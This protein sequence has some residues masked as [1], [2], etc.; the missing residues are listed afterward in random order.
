MARSTKAKRI[1]YDHLT[2]L[3]IE[4]CQDGATCIEIAEVA[5]VSQYM[6]YLTL[7]DL[8]K[9]GKLKQQHQTKKANLPLIYY[10]VSTIIYH[11]HDPFGI[12]Q[13]RKVS[14]PGNQAVA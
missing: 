2:N 8:V 14:E 7:K 10:T 11:A 4:M 13:V 3:I 12:A 6:V 9:D 5:D 1:D